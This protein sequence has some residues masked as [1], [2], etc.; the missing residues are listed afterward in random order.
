VELRNYVKIA[1]KRSKLI[2]FVGMVVGLFSFLFSIL[3]PLKYDVSLSLFISRDKT[4]RTDDF[5]YDGYYALRSGEL[6]ADSVVQWMKDPGTV[7]KIYKK[8]G[9]D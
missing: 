7:D 3:Q 8:A 6:I 1:K 2:L 4:Q 5:K 9:V